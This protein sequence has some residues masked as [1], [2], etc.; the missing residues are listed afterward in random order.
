MIVT[1]SLTGLEFRTQYLGK[2]KVYQQHP[3]FSLPLPNLLAQAENWITGKLSDTETKLLFLALLKST[4]LVTFSSREGDKAN[5]INPSIK[6]INSNMERLLSTCT[7]IENYS[8]AVT[9]PRFIVTKNNHSL[10][11][12]SIILDAWANAKNLARENYSEKTTREILDKKAEALDKLLRKVYDKPKTYPRILG[13]WALDV[14]NCP[15]YLRDS[16]LDMFCRKGTALWNTDKEDYELLLDYFETNA[17]FM[18]Y[19]SNGN[20]KALTTLRYLRELVK[21]NQE[22]C[23]G[24]LTSFSIV[25]NDFEL[26]SLQ[27][28]TNSTNSNINAVVLGEKFP[29]AEDYNNRLDFIKAKIAWKA[30]EQLSARNIVVEESMQRSLRK[31]AIDNVSTIEV[32]DTEDY[33]VARELLGITSSI[34]KDSEY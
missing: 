6:T 14:A 21:E 27:A 19:T 10:D 9:F 5:Y 13:T 11:N 2:V 3:V 30:R 7:W 34:L 22:G 17:V 8:A 12:I 25:E 28:I 15:T 1:C 29:V 33:E 31:A 18:E 16:W 23:L 24:S 32:E 26:N 20:L 4:D